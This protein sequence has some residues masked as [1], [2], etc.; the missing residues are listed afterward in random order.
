[1]I[2]MNYNIKIGMEF[3]LPALSWQMAD[4][5]GR[6]TVVAAI[7]N[8]DEPYYICNSDET[9]YVVR[10]DKQA[11]AYILG[12][13]VE[14]EVNK[15]YKGT[16]FLPSYNDNYYIEVEEEGLLEDLP[17]WYVGLNFTNHRRVDFPLWTDK[18]RY[19][20]GEWED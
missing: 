17:F 8:D 9:P 19:I 12:E 6:Y 13:E 4:I 2:K 14:A 11:L 7:D 20:G 10:I 3:E 5:E 1:M 18:W 16:E 15:V